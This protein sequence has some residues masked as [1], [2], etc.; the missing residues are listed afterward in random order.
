MDSSL[1]CWTVGLA[2]YLPLSAQI[3]Q[4]IIDGKLSDRIWQEA[5]PVHLT[6]S[7]PGVPADRGGEIRA[8]VAGRYLYVSARLPESG[9]FVAR[10]T[11]RNPSWEEEDSLRI[12]AGANIGYTDR[13]VQVNPLGAYSI[14]KAVPVTY[15]NEPTFPYS[16]EWER[17]VLYRD[18]DKFLVAVARVENEWDAEVAIPL[19]QLSAPG[20]DHMYIRVERVRAARPDSPPLS[21]HWPQYG[22]AGKVPVTRAIKWDDPAPALQ[23]PVIGNKEPPLLVG[24]R[25]V[26]P[27][28]TSSWDD[29]DWQ[30][31]P[32]LHLSR[33]EH[34]ARSP[35]WPTLV[36]MLHD[37]RTLAVIAKCVEPTTIISHI[38]ENDGAITRDDNFQ[39]YLS[40]SGSTYAQY[41]VNAGGYLL[42]TAGFAGGQRLSRAR[43]WSSGAKVSVRRQK[44]WWEARLDI[45][46]EFAAAALGE[47]RIP[48]EW[49]ILLTRFRP[50]RE[51]E[52][53]E[54]SVLPVI[55]SE[56]P[57]CPARYR[58][59]AFANG[60]APRGEES[61]PPPAG[62]DTRVLAPADRSKLNLAAM[63]DRHLRGR[64]LKALEAEKHDRDRIHT[65]EN[66]EQFRDVRLGALTKSLGRFPQRTPLKIRV[67]KE[68]DG[69]GYRRKDLLYESRPGLWVTA[70]L[71]MPAK[72]VKSMP[73]IAIIHSLHRPK[74]QAE[75]QDMGILWARAGCAVLIMDQ[76]GYGERLET[77]S[78]NREGYHSRYATGMQLS[79]VGE[80][81]IKWMVWDVMRGLDLLSDTPNVNR[82]QL[83]LLGAVAGGGDPAAVTAALDPRVAAV[84]PF[85]FGEASPEQGGGKSSWPDGL[86]DPGWGSWESTRNL[87][88]SIAHQ[89]FPWIIN[90]SVAPR[91]F[92]YS[93]ELGW[94]V[95]QQ[96]AWQRYKKVFGLYGAQDRLGE[97]HGF[98]DFP[99]PGECANIGPSQRQTMYPYLERWFD[100]PRPAT[101]P[102]DRR[103]ESELQCL[104][105]A[106]A[107]ELKIR[108]IHELA[109][110][111]AAAKLK[112]VRDDLQKMTAANRRQWLQKRWASKLGDIEPNASP[113]VARY[114]KKPWKNAAVEGLTLRVEP[115][116]LVPVLLL[117]PSSAGARRT[118]VVVA[119]AEAG[120]E[121]FFDNRAAEIES[122]LDAGIA[123]CLP[124]L[125]GT[126]ETSPDTRRDR[127][128]QE[129]SLAATELML[130]NTLLG[131]RLKD[132]RTV[133]E[134]LKTRPDLNRDRI[135][136]WGDSFAAPNTSPMMIDEMAGWRVGP[137]IQHQAEPMGG[138]LALLA[139]LYDDRMRALA[140][141]GGLSDYKSIL[142]DAF[143]YVPADV[144]VPGVL[145]CGD[146]PD[147][148]A[149]VA[150][151]PLWLD[152]LVDAKNRPLSKDT[153][154]VALATVR[155]AYRDA[156]TRLAIHSEAA[157]GLSAW[158]K[159]QLT[160]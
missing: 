36:K 99:G 16:D 118:P 142:N 126:G 34:N 37:G 43:E 98:G 35:R 8:V 28:L 66:W 158:L 141:R 30:N 137:T 7:M 72:P 130:D 131:A 32:E 114:W 124:D 6:P 139:A 24:Q 1:R 156:V 153:I 117:H 74:S 145:D 129:I 147:I 47:T 42:D 134:Y 65:R 64:V 85:N 159:A 14:E 112:S 46:V 51:G 87:P 19:N 90:A 69:D 83:I 59:L 63:L 101:E 55:E 152:R 160:P 78:W 67:S 95:N 31:V 57:L 155:S 81:L 62:F 53:R 154:N 79:L 125:R 54:T 20:S 119:I 70:N 68:F 73:G 80:S 138:I 148:M 143:P 108:T 105:P 136:V 29:A 109:S 97:A 111:L 103:P 18:A 9:S 52:A 127:S 135:A 50:G 23:A 76:I 122:L 25:S 133:I 44:G 13:I 71:Y 41:A 96:P 48:S 4:L 113:E 49:R 123:V 60:D 45:P 58:R 39:V 91:R 27:P 33:D 93:Y 38:K 84:V 3:P 132:L 17:S 89:F 2:L 12:L 61:G 140:I 116:I 15:R 5:E 110:D 107:A 86:A 128:G 88:G 75:L 11:G 151:L 56:T 10:L 157:A 40:T 102:D 100:I 115:G 94:D 22:P 106:L 92:L 144:V 121:G 150:P 77:Y 120:K 104:T 146:L 21:W 82:E 149:S 26:L